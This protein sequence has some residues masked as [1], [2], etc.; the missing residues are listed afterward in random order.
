VCDLSD[1]KAVD[2]MAKNIIKRHQKIDILINNAGILKTH[3]P[4]TK[5]AIDV[6]FVVNT[7]APFLLTQK[8][9]PHLNDQGRVINVASAAQEPVD[10]AAL[11][12]RKA[13]QMDALQAYSQSKL[14]IIMWSNAMAKQPRCQKYV[15]VSVNPG[16]LLASKM[17][18]E[19]FGIDGKD[20]NIGADIIARAALS[21]EF[22][23]A[24]GK[25]FDNDQ[26]VFSDPHPDALNPQKN[27]KI[28]QMIEHMIEQILP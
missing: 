4:M 20:I 27:M 18:K 13:I 7:I 26:A 10:V 9:L 25:Y 8:L 3:E 2:L 11:T 24:S 21:K 6:R 19:G 15:I 23:N 16:S 14:A 12:G 5:Y 28:M 17:V 22:V 1:L